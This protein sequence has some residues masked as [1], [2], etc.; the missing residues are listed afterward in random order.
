[1]QEL[2]TL[3]DEL[4]QQHECP[5]EVNLVLSAL[6]AGSASRRDRRRFARAH[7]LRVRALLRLFSDAAGTPPWELY[8]RDVNHRGLGF[9]TPH[10]LPLGYGGTLHLPYKGELLHIDATLIRCR[11]AAPGWYEGA[12]YFNREQPAL[13]EA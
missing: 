10:R 12:M 7:Q 13:A 2:I 3:D 11:Q 5:A 8:S 6:E 9:V 1:M 4:L